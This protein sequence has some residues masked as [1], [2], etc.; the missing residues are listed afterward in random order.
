MLLEA[1]R[2]TVDSRVDPGVKLVLHKKVGD[3]V[4]AG[5]PLATVHVSDRRRL[6][7]A[8]AMLRRALR[9][10]PQAPPPRPLVHAV[11]Q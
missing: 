9:I 10:G 8:L 4:S 7:E 5:E 11:L 6:D 3:T 1:G 2:E